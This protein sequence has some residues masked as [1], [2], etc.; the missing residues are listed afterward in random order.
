MPRKMHV[1]KDSRWHATRRLESEEEIG[2]CGRVFM[3]ADGA[4]QDDISNQ[5]NKVCA[6]CLRMMG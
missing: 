6:N 5:P 3:A 1:S 4:L 2:L